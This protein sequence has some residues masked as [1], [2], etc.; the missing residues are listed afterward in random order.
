MLPRENRLHKHSAFQATYYIKQTVADA[1]FVLYAGKRKKDSS[2]PTRI[3]FVV[4]KKVHKRSTKR[5][6][7]KRLA[8][9]AFRQI[10]KDQDKN[11]YQK[12]MSMIFQARS[13]SLEA[14]YNQVYDSI[15]SLIKRAEKKF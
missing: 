8:R 13:N 3:G 2:T 4:S 6:R 11:G 15:V 14:N 10:L 7:I 1:L 5:N 12:W 9:E